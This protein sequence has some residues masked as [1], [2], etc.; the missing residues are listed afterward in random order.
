MELS[1]LKLKKILVLFSYLL[2]VSKDKSIHSSS[3][4]QQKVYMS[5]IK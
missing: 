3:E 4:L 5:S 2:R 1:S